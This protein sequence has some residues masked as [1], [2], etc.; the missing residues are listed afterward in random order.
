MDTLE[1]IQEIISDKTDIRPELLNEET[2][3]D[4]IGADSIDMIEILMALEEEF[5]IVIPDEQ[6][7]KI[8]NLGEI[9]EYIEQNL[10]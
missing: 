8:K 6:A 10:S 7:Q 2:T 5:D 1:R 4:E 9:K 3:L